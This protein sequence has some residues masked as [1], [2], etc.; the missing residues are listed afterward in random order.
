MCSKGLANARPSRAFVKMENEAVLWDYFQKV[1]V[2]EAAQTPKVFAGLFLP[3]QKEAREVANA[4]PTLPSFGKKLAGLGKKALFF[5]SVPFY[6]LVF[7]TKIMNWFDLRFFIFVVAATIA[8][9]IFGKN[10]GLLNIL[11]K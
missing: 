3:A 2:R 6:W 1:Q 11:I 9:S 7:F 10:W 8:M 5:T 4:S